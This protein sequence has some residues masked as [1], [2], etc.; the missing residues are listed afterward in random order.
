MRRWM[1]SFG[2]ALNGFKTV[3]REE[4]NF[5]IELVF[6]SVLILLAAYF[7]FSLIEWIVVIACVTIV[8]TGEIVNTV[9]EDLCN[10]I[11]PKQDPAI[12]KI[13]DMAAAFVLIAAAG[14]GLM[15][16]LLILSHLF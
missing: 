13:K 7:D 9:I 15:G 16:G 5:Q 12:G 6:A 8:L 2:W 3:L 4:A 1:K 11:E 14:A 10:K